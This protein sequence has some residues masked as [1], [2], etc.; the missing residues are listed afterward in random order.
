MTGRS[1]LPVLLGGS[2]SIPREHVFAIRGVHSS[3]VLG[4]SSHSNGVDLGRAVRSSRYKLIVNYTPWIPYGPVDCG[5]DPGWM[6][7][8]DDHKHGRLDP[9]LDALYFRTP[10]PFVELYDLETDPA[11]IHNLAG[12][13]E[14]APTERQLK[15]ALQE[16]MITDYDY[17][18]LPL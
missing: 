8:L 15:E 4:P 12:L 11:E 9:A 10:R 7:L 14:F 3:A 18:P 2:Q 6:R 5:R 1:F 17:L 13:P 16:K